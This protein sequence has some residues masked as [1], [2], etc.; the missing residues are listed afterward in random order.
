MPSLAIDFGTSNC[1]AFIAR[2]DDVVPVALDGADTVMPSAVF[3]PRSPDQAPARQDQTF[4]TLLKEARTMLFG[5]PA[6]D[7]YIDDPL[8]G[9]LVRSPKS[10]LGSDIAPEH[11]RAFE[12]VVIAML[13]H[14]KAR[15]ETAHGAR[16]DRVL[17]GRPV[18]YHGTRGEEGNEQAI[19]VMKRA[20]DAAGFSEVRFEFEPMA[21]AYEYESGIA[22]EQVVLVVDVGGGTTDIVMLRASPKRR[23][24]ARREK[25]ILGV[26]GDRIGGTDF[27][28]LLA[29]HGFMGEFGKDSK[30]ASGGLA[31]NSLIFD[32]IS[33]RSVPSQLRFG[34]P[35][36]RREIERMVRDSAVPWKL[37]RLRTVQEQQLQHRLVHSAELVKIGLSGAESVEASLDYVE[38]NLA[39]TVARPRFA[40]ATARLVRSVRQLALETLGASGTKPDVIFL[41]GGMASSPVIANAV[42][43]VAGR[44][45]PLRSGDML[46]SV[47]RGLALR[48]QRIFEK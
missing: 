35:N 14:I 4:F 18:R 32:A 27:D 30:T 10:F 13:K 25:D 46:G 19:D 15:A 43:D 16:L 38:A 34:S 2:R 22:A 40:E 29:W 37:E 17:L 6:L 28:E 7:A 26:A 44:D 42:A 9:V 36:A 47:G 31:P 41:T 45:V 23:N 12:D 33:V 1:T 3:S 20:A 39:V 5:R 8:G 21:A 11:M 48:A 24:Q